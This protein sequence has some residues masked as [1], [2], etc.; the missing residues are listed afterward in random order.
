[1]DITDTMGIMGIMGITTTMVII[2]AQVFILMWALTIDTI[3]A[4]R[5][6]VGKN[7]GMCIADITKRLVAIVNH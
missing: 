6:V 4:T 2:I 7:T 1:M 5:N 3:N